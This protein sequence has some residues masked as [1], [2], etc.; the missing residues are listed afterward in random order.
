MSNKVQGWAWDVPVT[1]GLKLVLVALADHADDWGNCWPG[2]RGLAVKCG[3]TE[4]TVERHVAELAEAGWIKITPRYRP[5]GSRTSNL[6]YLNIARS[7][8]PSEDLTPGGGEDL[9]PLSDKNRGTGTPIEPSVLEPSEE[10]ESSSISPPFS[11]STA[12]P[13]RIAKRATV[14][15]EEFRGA[16]RSRF[17]G[18][19]DI[20]ERIDEALGHQA[21]AK[22][23]DLQAY[24]RGWLR[25]EADHSPEPKRDA[26]VER[27]KGKP[28]TGYNEEER[29]ARFRAD[30]E[31]YKANWAGAAAERESV[32]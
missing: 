4:R 12:R 1:G 8:S 29:I 22:Y 25:R 7:S 20:D 14:V 30:S 13:S 2:T 21:A 27:N 16:M 3:V 19:S 23:T 11:E 6:F 32:P 31:E 9:T 15:D 10:E 28:T 26:W 5:D 24:V 18:L 17:T